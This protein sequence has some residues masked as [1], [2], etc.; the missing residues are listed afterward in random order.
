M[1]REQFQ[2]GSELLNISQSLQDMSRAHSVANISLNHG[3]VVVSAT[4]SLVDQVRMA[5]N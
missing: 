4:Y 2:V 1:A 5:M 3:A